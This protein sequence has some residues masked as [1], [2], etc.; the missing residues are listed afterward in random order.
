MYPPV[1]RTDSTRQVLSSCVKGWE[2]HGTAIPPRRRLERAG[3]CV[4]GTRADPGTFG[5]RCKPCFVLGRRRSVGPGV[6]QRIWPATSALLAVV[7]ITLGTLLAIPDQQQIVYVPVDAA[8]EKGQTPQ[9]AMIATNGTPDADNTLPASSTMDEAEI[10]RPDVR[11]LNPISH[12]RS[13]DLAM[14]DPW[15]TIPMTS[16][17]SQQATIPSLRSGD[18]PAMVGDNGLSP[19]PRQSDSFL[20]LD[21]THLLHTRGS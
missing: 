7:S 3:T 2:F 12:L 1:P 21:W 14:G 11:W 4:E 19:V 18:W 17:T 16:Q 9:P 15:E 20:P 10:A 8:A 13:R 5:C 6:W